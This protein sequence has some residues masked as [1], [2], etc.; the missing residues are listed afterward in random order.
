MFFSTE[1]NGKQAEGYYGG[2]TE[3]WNLS[4]FVL[5]W[6]IMDN[7]I[8]PIRMPKLT[9]SSEAVDIWFEEGMILFEDPNDPEQIC[10]CSV[11]DFEARINGLT[12]IVE[13]YSERHKHNPDARIVFCSTQEWEKFLYKAKELIREARQQI[14]IGLPPDLI[15][16]ASKQTQQVP[17]RSGF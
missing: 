6:N 16:G 1:V 10:R 3:N 2:H 8:A 14:H 13:T 11:D 17:R 9:P 4:A 12:E 5:F 7:D 15:F